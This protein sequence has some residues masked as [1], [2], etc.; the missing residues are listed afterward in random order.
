MEA[1]SLTISSLQAETPESSWRRSETGKP[2]RESQSEGETD[3]PAH[4]G[5]E[6]E[7]PLASFKIK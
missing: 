3:V 4:T 1:A 7:L 2:M 5:W 6:C